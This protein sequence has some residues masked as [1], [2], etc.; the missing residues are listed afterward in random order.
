MVTTDPY[1][2]TKATLLKESELPD[3]TSFEAIISSIRDLCDIIQQ[4]PNIPSEAAIVLKN[5]DSPAFLIHFVA[6]NLQIGVVE[7]QQLLEAPRFTAES[8]RR[9]EVSA[10]RTQDA[11]TEKPDPGPCKMDIDKQQRE[12]FLSQQLKQIQEELGGSPGE[13]EIS[14]FMDRANRKNGMQKCVRPLIRK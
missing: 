3:E 7:K 6:S 4:S 11:G 5:I 2:Q 14:R 1:L 10:K 8:R 13:A 12:Y 9:I